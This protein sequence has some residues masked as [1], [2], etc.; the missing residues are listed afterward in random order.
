[1]GEGERRGWPSDPKEDAGRLRPNLAAAERCRL[2]ARGSYGKSNPQ[3]RAETVRKPTLEKELL[4]A[5]RGG[6]ANGERRS[7]PE[8]KI[9]ISFVGTWLGDRLI[10]EAPLRLH[11]RNCPGDYLIAIVDKCDNVD[12][13]YPVRR[14]FDELWWLTGGAGQRWS[15]RKWIGSPRTIAGR[16]MRDALLEAKVREV[17]TPWEAGELPPSPAY[18]IRRHNC[19]V[20]GNYLRR[21]HFYPRVVIRAT[22]RRWAEEFLRRRIGE[23]YQA[24]ISVPARNIPR[25]P[26]KNLDPEL[27]KQII[28]WLRGQGRFAFLLLGRDD[29][30][31]PLSGSDVF[32]FVGEKWTFDRTTAIMARTSLFIGGDSSLTHAA[33]GLRIPVI[34]VGYTANL[35]YPFTSQNRYILFKKAETTERIMAEVKRFVRRLSL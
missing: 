6:G 7:R 32:S 3:K 20:E 5:K 35:A 30:P 15:G 33:A 11:R 18:S 23:K 25:F 34:G 27:I 10:L 22:E 26:E 24:L 28:A 1:L 14:H 31:H 4:R 21:L 19:F 13:P 12:F 17:Y 8:K 9:A 2:L 29:G 16:R